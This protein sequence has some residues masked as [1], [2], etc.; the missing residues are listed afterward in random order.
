[1]IDACPSTNISPTKVAF[2]ENDHRLREMWHELRMHLGYEPWRDDHSHDG[3]TLDAGG[4]CAVWDRGLAPFL[5]D[6]DHH[7]PVL[8]R[9]G[10][11]P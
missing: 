3:W 9:L 4:T 6:P 5:E 7:G 2:N 8:Q 1:M 10:V 11:K